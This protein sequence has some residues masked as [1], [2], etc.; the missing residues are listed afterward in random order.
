MTDG[1]LL[2]PWFYEQVEAVW[3]GWWCLPLSNVTVHALTIRTFEI[4]GYEPPEVMLVVNDSGLSYTEGKSRIVFALGFAT[5]SIIAHE[6]AHIIHARHGLLDGR[7]GHSP[8]LFET[9]TWTAA[10]LEEAISEL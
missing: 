8:R 1:A 7:T 4:L 6:A 9:M 10:A 2:D 5:P 3:G